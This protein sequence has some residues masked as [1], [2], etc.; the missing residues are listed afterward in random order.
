LRLAAKK[1]DKKLIENAIKLF[2]MEP[3]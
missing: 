3:C 2:G 1:D